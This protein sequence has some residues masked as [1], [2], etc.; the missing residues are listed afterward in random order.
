MPELLAV[1]EAQR[2][3]KNREHKFFAAIQGIDL[4]KASGGSSRG[5]KEW[6]DLKSRVFSGGQAENSD[7]ILSL[8]GQNAAKAGF[9]IG[10][11]IEYTNAKD[12][13]SPSW[14]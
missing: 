6:E 10:N 3:Q 7:D 8:Q 2:E 9:G 12:L 5:Q 14:T 13:E 4:D 11:G 1:L